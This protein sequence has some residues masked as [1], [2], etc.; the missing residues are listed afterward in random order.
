MQYLV[1]VGIHFALGRPFR[2][3]QRLLF[4]LAIKNIFAHERATARKTCSVFT[5]KKISVKGLSQ[6]SPCSAWVSPALQDFQDLY[7]KVQTKKPSVDFGQKHVEAQWDSL[8]S[9]PP[10][11]ARPPWAAPEAQ[12]EWN[13]TRTKWQPTIPPP[14]IQAKCL[15]PSRKSQWLLSKYRTTSSISTMA[16]PKATWC[17]ERVV[18]FHEYSLESRG[19]GALFDLAGI[20]KNTSEIRS[21]SWMLKRL[22]CLIQYSD[23]CWCHLW[24]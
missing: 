3:I 24:W 2:S 17:L 19:C 11:W 21:W 6:G 20:R 8:E 23:Q 14:V 1:S 10:Q 18:L 4:G 13:S 9:R 5:C 16:K 15:K 7:Q 22:V 12:P